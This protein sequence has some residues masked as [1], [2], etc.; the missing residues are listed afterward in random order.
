MPGKVNPVI[1]EMLIQ[2]GAQVIGNDAAITFGGASG[3]FELNV[4]MPVMALNLLQ[5]IELLSNGVQVFTRRCVVGLEADAARCEGM[6]EQSLAL[7]TALAPAI[8]Y[9]QA[10]RIAK[11]AHQTGRTIREVAQEMAGLE[12]ARLAELLDVRR[13]TSPS[14]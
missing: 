6:I 9:D 11:T 8:G 7:A 13:Q 3:N 4:M 12:E 1:C 5:S 2:V 10:A 14:G